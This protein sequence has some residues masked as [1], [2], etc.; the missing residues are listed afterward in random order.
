MP[1]KSL[2]LFRNPVLAQ[3]HSCENPCYYFQL[4]NISTAGSSFKLNKDAVNEVDCDSDIKIKQ[5][6]M[7]VCSFCFK[8]TDALMH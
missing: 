7:S 2:N 3:Y 4:R 6:A 8:G 1:R 5:V